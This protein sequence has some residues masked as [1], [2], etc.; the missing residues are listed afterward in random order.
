MTAAAL[1]GLLGLNLLYLAAGAALLWALR[2]WRSWAET[3]RLA[4]LSYLTGVAL[5]GTLWSLALVAGIP[6]SL[7]FLGASFA[8]VLV[9]ALGAGLRLGRTVPT[10]SPAR[11]TR[12]G[13]VGAAGVAATCLF[14][15]ALFRAARLSGLYAWDAWS[16]W[17][18]KAKSIY[19]F[20][21]LDEQLLRSVPNGSYPPLIPVLDSAAFHFMGGPDV[22]TLHVQFWFFAA[23]FVFA[24]AGLLAE[25]VP[26]WLLW[27]SL[28]LVLVAPRVGDR[29]LTPQA[30]FLLDYCFV[31]AALLLL[32][33]LDDGRG[34][35]LTTAAVLLAAA[36]LTKR[37]GIMLAGCL[38][39]AALVA[40]ARHWR[41][42]WPPLAVTAAAVA[43]A[44]L[45]WR[46]W[47]AAQGIGSEL[48]PGG[49]VRGLEADRL[50]PSLRLSLEV[51]FDVRLWSLVVLLGCAA[52]ALAALVRAFQPAVFV[53]TLL[54][55][56]TLGGAWVTWVFTELPVTAEESANP[57]VRYTQ[58]AVLLLAVL[59]PP[60][61]GAVWNRTRATA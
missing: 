53:A 12:D 50:G 16:F 59:T 33:W 55:L 1:I 7:A 15:A 2:G 37:E 8:A 43:V 29:L 36:A 56:V 51:L 54:A 21:E 11:L 31:V 25:R 46:A 40:S 57:I 10:R 61:L 27:P 5:M 30:D 13:L 22:V 52:I 32:R 9:V 20:G 14:L 34:W 23:G 35:Q 44:A 18:P 39:A 42:R 48:P 19:F 4:G 6:L 45:P 47:Y 49:L 24:A 60:L 38:L 58:A 41:V 26:A 28:V 3:A 17:V